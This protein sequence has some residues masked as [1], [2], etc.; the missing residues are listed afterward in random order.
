VSLRDLLSGEHRTEVK[1]PVFSVVSTTPVESAARALAETEYHHLVV[2]DEESGKAVGMV[3]AVDL[4]RAL[5]HMPVK[6]PA[7]FP[8]FKAAP[9]TPAA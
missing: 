8:A 7:A 6:H 1:A 5:L 9:P 2:V 3:S 4:L